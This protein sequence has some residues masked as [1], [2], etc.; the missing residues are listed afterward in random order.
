MQFKLFNK[1]SKKRN[2]HTISDADLITK[3][4]DAS[5]SE[6]LKATRINLMYTLSEDEG[7]KAFLVTSAFSAEGKTSTSINLAATLAQTEAKV[8]LVDADLRK[9]RI[10]AYLDVK[11]KDGLANHLGGFASIESIIKRMSEFNF[12]YIT[13]G[14]IPP[15]PAELLSSKKFDT[16]VQQV[17]EHYDY[18]IFDTPPVNAVADAL[19]VVASVKNVVFICRCGISITS[20]VKKAVSALEFAHAKILGF[21]TIDAQGKKIDNYSTYSGYY[22]YR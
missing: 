20:E 8:L 12:D 9:P 14:D 22:Y 2:L 18:V 17:K 5:L 13:A 15:N 10:H 6:A 16:F 1:K 11:N 3:N 19:S 21:V 4:P 7:G